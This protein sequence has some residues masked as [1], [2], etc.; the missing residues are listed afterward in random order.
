MDINSYSNTP[1]MLDEDNT[2]LY[3]ENDD[4]YIEVTKE[5]VY[6]Y[7]VFW[8][9]AAYYNGDFEYAGRTENESIATDI[10]NYIKDRYT[11]IPPAGAI[12]DDIQ[13]MINEKYL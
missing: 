1:H 11:T 4:M 8:I 13:Q 7:H 6:N 5:R 9:Y 3:Y 10:F 2:A 12:D